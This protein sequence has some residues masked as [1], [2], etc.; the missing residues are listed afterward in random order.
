MKKLNLWIKFEKKKLDRTEAC[1]VPPVESTAVLADG[2]NDNFNVQMSLSPTYVSLTPNKLLTTMSPTP[3]RQSATSLILVTSITM[4]ST[5]LTP[6]SVHST[7]PANTMHCVSPAVGIKRILH[8][9]IFTGFHL[10][11]WD[12]TS[13]VKTTVCKREI[14]NTNRKSQD[15]HWWYSGS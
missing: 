10:H 9:E 3:T 4:T 12:N 5:V 14:C 13:D 11:Q 1:D 7:H 15:E 8:E 2:Y 6:I